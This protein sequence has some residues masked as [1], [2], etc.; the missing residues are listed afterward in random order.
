MI[1]KSYIV[2]QDVGLLKKY[3]A[4]LI[5][6]ENNGIKDDIK[7]I[8]KKE[9]NTEE[10]I[11][12]FEQDILKNK[13]ILQQNISNESLFNEKKIIFIHEASDK[14]FDQ[15][16]ECLEKENVNIKFYIFS[17]KL[18][19]KTKLRNLFEKNKHL[20]ILP[21]YEDSERTLMSYIN[22]ELKEYNGLSGEITNLIISNSNMDRRIVRSE[23][24][25]IK[26]YFLKKKINKD[27]VQEILNFKNDTKFD[28]LRDGALNGE[29]EKINKLLSEVDI[30]NENTFFYLNNLNN[31]IMNLLE[32]IKIMYDN[33]D[34]NY[35]KAFSSLKPPIFWKDKPVLIR[36]LKKW[37]IK[38]L[39]EL[40]EKISQ[41]ETLMK[42]N[43][44]LRNDIM[45]KNLIVNV[46]NKASSIYS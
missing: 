44:Y 45:I 28:E 3:Q 11:N 24:I 26:D 13:I 38:K 30:L 17:Q 33:G 2:E 12:I 9:K 14:I 37:S 5:Y 4:T 6:G 20:A 1:L 36:Q 10:I 27:E 43:S 46:T 8:V 35:E 7:R 29:H 42:K 21:C 25:K 23:L 19:K 22:K 41:T 40:A 32:I 16:E 18:D 15:I 31:R 39:S 34:D